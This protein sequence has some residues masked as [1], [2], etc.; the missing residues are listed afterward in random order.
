VLNE[1]KCAIIPK[2]ALVTEE[3]DLDQ[4]FAKA[5][6]EISSQTKGS[7]GTRY[8][9]QSNWTD[10]PDASTD[11]ASVRL[12]ATKVLFDSIDTF[13]GKEENIERFYLPLF[14]M[15]GSEY[16]VKHVLEVFRSDHRWLRSTQRTLQ[17][18]L[19]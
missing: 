4:L 19:T 7:V 14:A 3:P 18:L 2:G 9:F 5:V 15:G 16:A 17:N 12:K 13:R 10:E 8:G 1:Y 11:D 6:S